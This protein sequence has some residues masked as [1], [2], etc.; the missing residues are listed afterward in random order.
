MI[1]LDG[2]VCWAVPVIAL[3]ALASYWLLRLAVRGG[4]EDV[5]RRQQARAARS[6]PPVW[7]LRTPAGQPDPA[8]GSGHAG[9]GPPEQARS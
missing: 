1:T 7:N 8:G 6:A 4:V 3:T 2:F 5:A 9:A